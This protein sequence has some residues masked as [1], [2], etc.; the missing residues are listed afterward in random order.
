MSGRRHTPDF[1]GVIGEVVAQEDMDISAILL[2]A[3]IGEAGGDGG[4]VPRNILLPVG[5]MPGESDG[6]DNGERSGEGADREAD[7]PGRRP[8]GDGYA[9]FHTA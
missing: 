4:C 8:G 6:Q 1:A 3:D 9:R 7:L 2:R 5:P